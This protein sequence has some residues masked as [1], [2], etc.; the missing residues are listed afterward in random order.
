MAKITPAPIRF[1]APHKRW[2]YAVFALLWLSGAWWLVAH[3]FMR[4]P[5]AFGE[6]PHPMEIWWLRLHGLM[7]FAA[8]LTLGSVLSTHAQRAWKLKKNRRT[9]LFMK[10]IFLWLAMSGYALYYFADEENA[11]WL[12]VLHWVVG[13]SVPLMLVFHIRHGRARANGVRQPVSLNAGESH[14]MQCK[15][16]KAA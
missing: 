9:G 4:V 7:V 1:S 2:L 10:A 14:T 5:G 8:L 3:Y 12:P 6:T 16:K 13:L 15:P 11:A